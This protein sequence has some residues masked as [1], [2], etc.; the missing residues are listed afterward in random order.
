MTHRSVPFV[1]KEIIDKW[2]KWPK[3]EGLCRIRLQLKEKLDTKG[4]VN[5]QADRSL[6]GCAASSNSFRARAAF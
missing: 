6:I 3:R 5:K 4:T 1:G 2:R